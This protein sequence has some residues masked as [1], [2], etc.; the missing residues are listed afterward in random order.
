MNDKDPNVDE[1]SLPTWA[2]FVDL[3]QKEFSAPCWLF[4]GQS[5]ARW[6]LQ[7]SFERAYKTIDPE[8]WAAV[9][10][11]SM[12]AFR[13]RLHL[14]DSN[15]PSEGDALEWL[16]LMQHHGAP[17]RLLDWTRSPTIAAYF[18]L[19][20]DFAVAPALWLINVL[21]LQNDLYELDDDLLESLAT[22]GRTSSPEV[23]RKHVMSNRCRALYPVVPFVTDAGNLQLQD[24]RHYLRNTMITG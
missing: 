14:F 20:G 11:Y 23:F 16:A 15:P 3:V 12:E 7:S 21:I 10:Q 22:G 1:L 4:R 18:A 6:G 19:D 9:E 13:G 5:D 2:D 24:F 8:L 17:T